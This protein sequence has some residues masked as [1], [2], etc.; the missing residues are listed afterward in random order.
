MV[1]T[2]QSNFLLPRSTKWSLH[3]PSDLWPK[4][5]NF[6][7]RNSKK[8]LVPSITPPSHLH[9]ASI[10]PPWASRAGAWAIHHHLASQGKGQKRLD[11][12][13]CRNQSCFHRF[14]MAL[15]GI[16]QSPYQWGPWLVPIL[17]HLHGYTD[18]CKFG[19]G[20][21][22]IIPL[23][24]NTNYYIYWSVDF[25]PVVIQQFNNDIISINDLEM[26]GVLLGWLVALEHLLP[27]LQHILQCGMQCDNSATVSWTKKFAAGSFW[28]GHLFC[29]LA[30][31]Q[32][33]CRSAPILVI[34]I[35]GL[36][37]NMADIA[38]RYSS[39]SKIAK[40]LNHPRL[41]L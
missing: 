4:R 11:P 10:T 8:L 37:N 34:S 33:V 41:L 40:N 32:Q 23:A 18:A 36:L 14:Q 24:N 2:I 5:R 30:L 1:Q 16:R 28:A 20:G 27:I 22:W 35:A 26:V 21:V 12:I 25:S 15:Q 39:S 6:D 29:T 31:H 38:S 13:N 9:H 7:S 17:P 19:A 3:V